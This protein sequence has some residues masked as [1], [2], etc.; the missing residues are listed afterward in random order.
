MVLPFANIGGDPEQEYFVDGVTESLTTDLSRI[1]G[2]FVIAR[3]TAY[4][5]K[6]KAFDVTNVGRELNVRYVLEGSV[7]RG[8]NRMRVNV[9]PIN[10]QS[11]SHLWAERFEKPVTDLFELQDEIVAR[12][13]NTLNA[14]LR[15]VAESSE[16][17]NVDHTR[18]WLWPDRDRKDRARDAHSQNQNTKEKTTRTGLS[19][20]RLARS[21]GV[22]V[23]PSIA[24]MAPS[25]AAG[26]RACH[27][28]VTVSE[29]ANRKIKMAAAGPK[30]ARNSE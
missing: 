16:R 30:S 7:Q 5:F 23:S 8:R 4:T 27:V 1:S 15:N 11:G 29:P 17:T 13:A 25:R 20:D 19:V 14:Q 10:S 26:N 18:F 12:I 28:E 24:W 9:Q 22:T 6:G 3:N 2:A 21:I